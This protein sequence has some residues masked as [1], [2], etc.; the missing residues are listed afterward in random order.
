[1][2]SQPCMMMTRR[3][4]WEVRGI[5]YDFIGVKYEEVIDNLS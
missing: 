3:K 2:L 5:N 1:M 4:V